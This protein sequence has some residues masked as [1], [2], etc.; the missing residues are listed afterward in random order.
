MDTN[1]HNR[2]G[3]TVKRRTLDMLFS[4][5]GVG[6]AALLLIVGVVMSSNAEW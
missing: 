4:I 6:L 5:G 3:V 1:P 2:L